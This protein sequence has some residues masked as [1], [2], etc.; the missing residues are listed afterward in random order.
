MF[1]SSL[2][3]KGG[4][5]SYLRSDD[6]LQCVL[7]WENTLFFNIKTGISIALLK[8]FVHCCKDLSELVYPTS[9]TV[10]IKQLFYKSDCRRMALSMQNSTQKRQICKAIAYISLQLSFIFRL[11]KL[12]VTAIFFL[13]NNLLNK[14]ICLVSIRVRFCCDKV[15]HAVFPLRMENYVSHI[16]Q[17]EN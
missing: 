15:V 13:Q 2:K 14:D 17:C 8:T 3:T 4:N 16:Q 5:R 9:A 11:L 10:H 1:D 12:S 6:I 7:Q